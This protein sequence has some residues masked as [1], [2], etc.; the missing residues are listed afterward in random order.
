MI[1]IMEGMSMYEQYNT[2]FLQNKRNRPC[3][4]ARKP[5]SG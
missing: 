3:K 5:F 1:N 2:I 4:K